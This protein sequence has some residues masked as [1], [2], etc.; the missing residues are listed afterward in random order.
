[1]SDGIPLLFLGLGTIG[2]LWFLAAAA[3]KQ[4]ADSKGD[5]VRS[6]FIDGHGGPPRPNRPGTEH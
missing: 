1:M 5:P 4:V 2:A 6:N 3:R